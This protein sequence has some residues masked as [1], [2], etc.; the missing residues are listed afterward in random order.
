[1]ILSSTGQNIYPEEIEAKL[2]NLP[3]I[4]ESVVVQ[5]RNLLVAL[6]FPDFPAM[7]ESGVLTEHLEE[8]M[9]ENKVKLNKSLANYEQV[10]Y[11]EMRDTEFEKTPKKSVKRFLYS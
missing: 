2:N 6:I 7:E 3:Y 4:A 8:I 11:M 5:R 1:M 10:S 9:K